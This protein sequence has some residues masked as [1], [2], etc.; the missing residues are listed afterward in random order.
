MNDM[1]T[2]ID[3]YN[4]IMFEC[5]KQNW[6]GYG[7][8]PISDNALSKLWDIMHLMF[9]YQRIK[10]LE[11][12]EP[13][14]APIPNGGFQLEFDRGD[15]YQLNGQTHHK[16]HLEIEVFDKESFSAEMLATEYNDTTQKEDMVTGDIDTP[17][18][19]LLTIED[20]FKQEAME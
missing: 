16:H 1:K 12:T 15:T 11:W 13:F 2:I 18:D 5:R 4:S 3:R 14:I 7:A 6:D 9:Y 19:F 8:A 17:T 20:F 10:N